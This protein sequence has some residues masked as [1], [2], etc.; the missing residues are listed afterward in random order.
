MPH[1]DLIGA[2]RNDDPFA[3]GSGP[4]LPM[5]YDYGML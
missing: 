4:H 2:D 1:E 5:N 3:M